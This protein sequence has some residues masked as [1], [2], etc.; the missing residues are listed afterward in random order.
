MVLIR[1]QSIHGEGGLSAFDRQ[2]LFGLIEALLRGAVLN[3][4]RAR[5]RGWV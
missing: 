5:Q 1:N 4:K 2:E 3:W